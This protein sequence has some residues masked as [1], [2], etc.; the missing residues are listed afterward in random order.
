MLREKIIIAGNL[1][2][3]A[4]SIAMKVHK[5]IWPDRAADPDQEDILERAHPHF[6][7]MYAGDRAECWSLN[8]LGVHPD[9]QGKGFGRELVRWGLDQAKAENVWAAVIAAKGKD[10]FYKN[11]GFEFILG[12]GGMGEGNPLANVEGANMHWKAPQ[13]MDHAVPQTG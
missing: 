2:K 13:G 1:L 5:L 7:H 6:E 10:P 4:S 11:C 9:Y 12:S 8:W 3:P